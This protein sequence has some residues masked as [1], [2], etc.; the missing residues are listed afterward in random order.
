M[1]EKKDNSKSP[2][3]FNS[4]EAILKRLNYFIHEINEARKNNDSKTMVENMICYFKEIN[5]KLPENISEVHWKK[6]TDLRNKAFAIPDNPNGIRGSWVS[7]QTVLWEL[8]NLDMKIR[9]LAKQVGLSSHNI[10]K[11]SGMLS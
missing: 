8:D 2:I 10:N 7:P 9:T 4:M 6:L 5:E 11:E 3:E 1:M